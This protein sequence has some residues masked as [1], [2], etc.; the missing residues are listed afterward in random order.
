MLPSNNS[1]S[2]NQLPNLPLQDSGESRHI[3]VVE[4]LLASWGGR[5]HLLS[6]EMTGLSSEENLD[7]LERQICACIQNIL[8][9]REARHN[10]RQ[11]QGA[12]AQSCLD[13]IQ[14]VLNQG[15]LPAATYRG[16]ARRLITQLSEAQD[17]LPSSLFISG[18]SDRDEHPTF[19]GG[20]G[21][22]YRA[23]YEGKMVALKRIRTFT[24]D[25]TSHRIRLEFCREALVWQGLRHRFILPFIGIDRETFSPSFCMV[26]PWMKKGTVLTYLKDRGRRDLDRLLLETAQGLDYLHAQHIVHGDLRGTNILISDD[27]SAR[28]SDFGL[29]AS[30]SDAESTTAKLTSSSNHGGSVR[31]FAPE[32]ISPT[33]FGCERFARTPASDVYAYACVC[34]ELYTGSPPF[35]E[36]K[37]DVT[38]ML[39]VIQGERPSQPAGMSQGLWQLVTSA[40]AAE[41][42][43]RPTI[44]HIVMTWPGSSNADHSVDGDNMELDSQRGATGADAETLHNIPLFRPSPIPVQTPVAAIAVVAWSNAIRV[45]TQSNGEIH[46]ACLNQDVNNIGPDRASLLQTYG[47]FHGVLQKSCA[48]ESSLCCISWGASR[49]LSL[50]YQTHDGTI[51]EMTYRDGQGWHGSSFAETDARPGTHMAEVHNRNGDCVMFFFQD[52]AGFLCYRRGLNRRWGKSMRLCKA[53]STTPITATAWDD[54]RHIRLYFQNESNEVQEYMGS[55]KGDWILGQ[56]VFPSTSIL[57]SMAAISWPGPSIRVYMQDGGN[58]LVQWC[59]SLDSGWTQSGFGATALPNADIAAFRRTSSNGAFIHVYWMSREGILHQK[60]FTDSRGWLET[61]PVPVRDVQDY[62]ASSVFRNLMG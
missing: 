4:D 62:W 60:V 28:L 35:S 18:V 57:G 43:T 14:H 38:A 59:Y 25:S 5:Q 3:P 19:A 15:S 26:S 8:N 41:P 56:F 53:A 6:A 27:N 45:Y 24:M 17:Q 51:L 36:I 52:K 13:A 1:T 49:N 58:S 2:G 30:I 44:R 10:V 31:W 34:L 32:L 54:T 37:L 7:D 33:T 39:C 9:S 16:Q 46:E 48:P 11:L 22:I 47:W 23:S 20:F 21:D 50:F 12:D 61:T 55:F 40:W 42:H 29:A